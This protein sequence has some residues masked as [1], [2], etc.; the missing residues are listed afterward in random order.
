[1]RLLDRDFDVCAIGT[2]PSL[3]T[4]FEA[5]GLRYR[6]YKMTRGINPLRDLYS[7]WQ[8]VRVFRSE[9]PSIVHTFDSKPAI[10]GRLAARLARVPVVIGTL[11]GLGSL[12][13]APSTRGRL[14]RLVYQPLQTVAC[15]WADLTT[16][17]NEDDLRDFTRRRVVAADRALVIPG[18]GIST[19]Q[20]A[21]ADQ[22]TIRARRA[23]LGLDGGVVAVMISRVVRSKGVLDFAAAA[24]AVR[25]ADLRVR[26]VLVGPEDRNSLDALT[27]PE[28]EELRSSLT[29]LG[30]R[31]DVRDVLTAADIFVFPSFYREGVPRVLL[32]AAAMG[33]PLVAAD[34]PGSRDVV[35]DGVNGFLVRPHDSDAVADAVLRL[36][37]EQ[38]KS[39]RS[40]QSGH[41]ASE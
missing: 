4:S 34:V 30:P 12:Y 14:V 23:E 40:V 37:R 8:L 1:M 22:R 20:F 25:G 24:R 38:H 18:S 35:E 32:E 39:R 33:L 17:Q 27:A 26:F 31:D 28:L 5:R 36:A 3:A 15:R 9:R 19:D 16:F 29:W 10:W 2:E 21:P 13:A 6:T 11:P 7:L 41:G